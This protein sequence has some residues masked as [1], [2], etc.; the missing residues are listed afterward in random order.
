MICQKMH[1]AMMRMPED[2]EE[3]RDSLEVKEQKETAVAKAT[4][5]ETDNKL[6]V[7]NLPYTETRL[8]LDRG[9]VIAAGR[10]PST[11]I[12]QQ[13]QEIMAGIFG[14]ALLLFV[15]SAL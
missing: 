8:C 9:S 3:G 4:N 6:C 10:K 12:K 15:S 11:K 2:T 13:I 1:I 5:M 7:D 14:A